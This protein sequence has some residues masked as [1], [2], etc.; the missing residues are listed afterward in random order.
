MKKKHIVIISALCA[1]LAVGMWSVART[2]PTDVQPKPNAPL[3]VTTLFPLE[4]WARMLGGTDIRVVNIVPDGAE[5]H[6]YEPTAE[7]MRM[8]ADAALV[9]SVGEGFD[10]RLTSSVP[11]EK[12][13]TFLEHTQTQL[14]HDDQGH[15]DDSHGHEEAAFDP[16]VWLDAE[17]AQEMVAAM[18][19]ALSMFAP[20]A[21]G[22]AA[23]YAEQLR[24]MDERFA[25]TLATCALRDII[26]AHDAYGYLENRYQ[27]TAHPVMGLSPEGEPDANTVARIIDEARELGVT[28][29]FFEAL[30][31]DGVARIIADDV[32]ATV[33]VLDPLE[34]ITPKARRA[35]ATYLGIMEQNRQALTA[36]LQCL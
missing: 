18:G 10:D 6:D 8:L 15:E 25:Q 20:Q 11:P 24:A 1:L 14:V 9:V 13:L 28:T 27:I 22:R 30:V 32:G 33:E 21:E 2:A 23:E 26:V 5:P 35:G 12:L 4:D 7:D 17:N 16:H 34:G 29:I 3:V 36:A 31:D 19:M